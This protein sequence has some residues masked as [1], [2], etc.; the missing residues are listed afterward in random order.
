[1]TEEEQIQNQ[2][3][4]PDKISGKDTL[5]FVLIGIL[6]LFM[7]GYFVY[8]N[9][10]VD[11]STG[12]TCELVVDGICL[13]LDSQFCGCNISDHTC[14]S[15]EKGLCNLAQCLN[16]KNYTLYYSASCP[17]CKRQLEELYPFQDSIPKIE[18]NSNPEQCYGI[19]GVPVWLDN[20]RKQRF[21]GYN[22]PAILYNNM[23]K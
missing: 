13:D 23:C 16:E 14:P 1:M 11:K 18:C 4:K 8:N 21:I 2:E 20:E 15:R 17:H 12:D 9:F 10:I 22:T 5:F 19:S 6:I 3:E 7:V